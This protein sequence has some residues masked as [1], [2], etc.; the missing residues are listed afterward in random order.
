MIEDKKVVYTS[1][2]FD[3]FHIGHLNIIK[4]SK[5]LGDILIVG[6]ST[7]ELVESYKK[8]API[9]PYAD[10]K[11][12]VEALSEV[13]LVVKQEILTDIKTLEK[14]GVDIV[15]IGDDW[16]TKYLEGLE[17]MKAKEGKEVYYLP[18][19]ESV[20]TTKIKESIINGWQEDKDGYFKR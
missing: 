7:D 5:E 9:I 2:T 14:F 12:I 3:L 8:R 17:W 6:V 4:K 1:G 13:D 11:A 18:Y 19:T 20:S 15:T 16:K 10:R